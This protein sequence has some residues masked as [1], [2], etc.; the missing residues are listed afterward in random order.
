MST[1]AAYG[2]RHRW[3]AAVA[4]GG[5]GRYAAAAGLLAPLVTGPDPVT[6]ALAGATLASH[7]RQLGGHAVARSWDS[8]AIRRLGCELAATPVA[9]D[10]DPDGI[11][12]DGALHDVLLGLAADAIGLGRPA[13]ATRFIEAAW[14]RCHPGWRGQVRAGWVTAELALATG[15]TAAAVEAAERAVELVQPVDAPRH[16]TKSGL[17]L[18]AALATQ[19]TERGRGRAATL[20][21][22]AVSTSLERGFLPLLWPSALLLAELRPERV[23]GC[24]ELAGSALNCIFARSDWEGRRLVLASPWMPTALLQTSDSAATDG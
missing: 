8:A 17:V 19:G 4:L 2:L 10:P 16:N 22:R 5:Q 6:A 15:S 12:A 14:L 23:K 20:L 24:R 7:R 18:A 9:G 21:D 1:A 13:P 11:D 3:L